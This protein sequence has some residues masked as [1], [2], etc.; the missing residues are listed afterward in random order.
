MEVEINKKSHCGDVNGKVPSPPS[1]CT[2]F[3][4]PALPAIELASDRLLHGQVYK[5]AVGRRKKNAGTTRKSS[6]STSSLR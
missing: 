6:F 4:S 3:R 5:R 1:L 2:F